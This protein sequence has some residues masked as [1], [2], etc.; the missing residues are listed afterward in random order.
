MCLFFCG[1]QD[2][3][4]EPTETMPKQEINNRLTNRNVLILTKKSD[5][6]L[7]FLEQLHSRAGIYY[8]VTVDDLTNINEYNFAYYNAVLIIEYLRNGSAPVLDSYMQIFSGTNNIVLLGLNDNYDS[9]YPVSVVT[10]NTQETEN[11][12]DS[13]E[14]VY[15]LLK[16]K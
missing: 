7:Q 16:T 11:L 5:Y 4:L 13:A 12:R 6:T 1:C 14:A 15:I 9:P 10:A 2:E 3:N 8:S